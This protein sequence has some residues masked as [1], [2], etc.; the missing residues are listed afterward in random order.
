MTGRGC[1]EFS[2]SDANGAAS[3]QGL[4]SD[5]SSAMGSRDTSANGLNRELSLE[6]FRLN[7]RPS[8]SVDAVPVGTHAWEFLGG[9]LTS[10][11]EGLKSQLDFKTFSGIRSSWGVSVGR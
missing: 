11:S 1:A 3:I 5:F 8:L 6:K 7:Q 4:D 9:S 2:G 10:T